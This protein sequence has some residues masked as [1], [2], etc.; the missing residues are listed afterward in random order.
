MK[1]IYPKFKLLALAC[2][3]FCIQACS[4]PKPGVYKDDQISNGQRAD[5]HELNKSA[6]S[7]IKANKLKELQL[8]MSK[9]MIDNAGNEHMVELM[10]NRLTDNPYDVVEEYYVVG[11]HKAK[12]SLPATGTDVNRHSLKYDTSAY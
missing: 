8:M 4:P 9:D 7:S 12:D 11:K 3:V 5:L 10:S 6:L 2:L 1:P